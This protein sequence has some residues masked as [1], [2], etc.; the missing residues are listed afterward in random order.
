[1][2]LALALLACLLGPQDDVRSIDVLDSF[3]KAQ[4]QARETG[5]PLVLVFGAPWCSASRVFERTLPPTALRRLARD[6]CWAYL[7]ID[8]NVE[9]A[10]SFGV[11]GTPHIIVL[12]PDGGRLDEAI[13]AL[14]PAEL[15][16]FLEHAKEQTPEPLDTPRQFYDV[17]DHSPLLWKPEGF[18][19][20]SVPFRHVGYGPLNLPSQSPG[21]VLRQG[22][23]LRMP[24]TLAKGEAEF[25]WS[26][27]AAN[28]FAFHRRDYRLDYL[29]LNSVLALAYGVTDGT[30]VELKFSDLSRFDSVLDPITD[31]FHD[32]FGL[33]DAGRE[34]FPERE[35]VIDLEPREGVEVHDDNTGSEARNLTLT[36]QH[37]LTH[38]TE[39]LPAV[40]VA[41]D[42]N[43][44]LGG[45]ADLE[46][47]RHLSLGFSTSLARRFREEFYAYLGVGHVWY[48]PD[49]ARGLA[50]EDVQWSGLA[51]LEW[52]YAPRAAWIV[53]YLV[54]SGVTRNRDPFDDSSHEIN[55]GWKRELEPGLV[56]EVGL[57]E[58]VIEPD[59]SPD[60]G[61]HFAIRRRF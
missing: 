57:I 40:S 18:R 60:F 37:T 17:G 44:H 21:Q 1:M 56:I 8:R 4:D 48:G 2:W 36:L 42:T 31:T 43:Y 11:R 39:L 49:E 35:N 28:F 29:T 19:A 23:Q 10:R 33:G 55:L 26:E 12:S 32:I 47:D 9:L 58:N 15:R 27:T 7:D 20:R 30:L 22:L 51:A 14:E 3:A 41:V 46:G 5:R 50:L 24:S 6:F 34:R 38:G 45:N 54:T 52:R 25:G 16:A 59:S 61:L 53:Q 13:G